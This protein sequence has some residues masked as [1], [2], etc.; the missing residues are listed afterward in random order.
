M[1]DGHLMELICVTPRAS[2]CGNASSM[3]SSRRRS[4]AASSGNRAG[5]ARLIERV[6]WQTFQSDRDH[7]R[8]PPDPSSAPSAQ[9]TK[10]TSSNIDVALLRGRTSFLRVT[11]EFAGTEAVTKAFPAM[12]E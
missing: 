5:H 12:M 3:G 2:S 6:T 10:S 8:E 9:I 11:T 1:T 7:R 4:R